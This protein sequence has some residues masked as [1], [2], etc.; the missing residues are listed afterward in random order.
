M[1]DYVAIINRF[2]AEGVIGD[3]DGVYSSWMTRAPGG[4]RGCAHPALE[5][6]APILALAVNPSRWR[7]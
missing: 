5:R 7:A 1:T 4:L 2:A 6:V 3:M